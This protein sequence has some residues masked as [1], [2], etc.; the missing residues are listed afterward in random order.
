[1]NNATV[2]MLFQEPV[3]HEF[4]VVLARAGREVRIGISKKGDVPALI[5]A[6]CI[7]SP[8]VG[9]RVL[10]ARAGEVAYVLSVL[11]QS[12]GAPSKLVFDRDLSLEVRDGKLSLGADHGVEVTSPAALRVV[13]QK[14][15]TVAKEIHSRFTSLDLAGDSLVSK[16]KKVRVLA[17]T[18]DTV[19]SRIYQ[20]AVNFL[21]RTEEIDRVEA[22]QI[23]MR[24]EEL[25]RVHGENAI[26][27]AD[28]LVK[29]NAGQVHVG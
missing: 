23:D 2:Q 24:A 12:D 28:N 5:A 20:R 13:V 18:F 11:E 1:M 17:E 29:I 21:R 26:T 14:V 16:T 6:S 7:L 9:D 15:E 22:K 4:G 27:S 3:T 8:S 10:V 19:A 25:I